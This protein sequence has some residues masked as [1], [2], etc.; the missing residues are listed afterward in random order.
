M[1]MELGLELGAVVG[2][3]DVDA[4]REAL[5]HFVD[6]LDSPALIA[7]VVHLQDSNARAIIDRGEL[8]EALA[9]ARD[10]LEELH[11]EL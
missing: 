4:E 7:A 9:R 11:I 3:D 8:I 1:P 6:E 10:A 2:L 5:P